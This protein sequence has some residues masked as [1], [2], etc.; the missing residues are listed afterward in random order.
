MAGSFC[1]HF[2]VRQALSRSFV[3]WTRQ[4]T[5]SPRTLVTE[6]AVHY[7]GARF[8]FYGEGKLR[9]RSLSRKSA[10]AASISTIVGT[11]AFVT[12]ALASAGPVSAGVSGA[13][14]TTDD[15]GFAV[16]A[17]YN[18]TACLNGKGTN[19]NIY[20]DKRNVFLSGLPVSAA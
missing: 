13:I 16:T 11:T 12:V 15:P 2:K 6:K 20:Q 14:S 5:Q 7:R 18:A 10:L 9:L 4:E 19:C 8:A 17:T 3:G 1:C